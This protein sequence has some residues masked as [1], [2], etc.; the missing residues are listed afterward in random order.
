MA[1]LSLSDAE[2]TILAELGSP[3]TSDQLTSDALRSARSSW[4]ALRHAVGFADAGQ[5]FTTASTNPKL[6]KSGLPTVGVT[7]HSTVRAR[8]PWRALDD[9]TRHSIASVLGT[10]VDEV[11]SRLKL[12]MCEHAT[13]GCSGVCSPSKSLN[14]QVG[15]TPLSRLIRT[16]FHLFRPAEAFC[17]TADGLRRLAAKHGEDCRWRVNISDDIRWE[18]L[19]PGLLDMGVPA[20]CYTKW[21]ASERPARPGLSVVYSATEHT[22]DETIVELTRKG[23]R[24]AVVF[25]TKPNELPGRWH[26]VEVSDGN[27]TDDLWTHKPGTI[28]GLSP[29]GPSNRIKEQ[30][31]RSGFARSV[32]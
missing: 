29:K 18:L 15:K 28:V 17:L 1:D 4:L 5:W 2:Q 9:A 13:A 19:A 26:G 30:M 23:E 8:V 16:L 24:V 27:V 10:D 12:T 32:S 11:N 31:R 20:Y 21:P 22:S 3:W 6:A 7:L 25:D 14:S